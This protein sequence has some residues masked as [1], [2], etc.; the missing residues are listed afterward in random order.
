[1]SPAWHPSWCR[2]EDEH[3]LHTRHYKAGDVNV[4]LTL[5]S[6]WDKPRLLLGHYRAW[7]DKSN[8][9]VALSDAEDMAKLMA[10]LGHEDIAALITQAAEVANDN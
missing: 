6:T 9:W 8:V 5:D 2:R 7:E 4:S 3:D 10:A 1:M